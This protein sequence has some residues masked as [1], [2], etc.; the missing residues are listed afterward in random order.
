MKILLIAEAMCKDIPENSEENKDMPCSKNKVMHRK[1]V[2]DMQTTEDANNL[3]LEKEFSKAVENAPSCSNM[4]RV[5]FSI[6]KSKVIIS[7]KN[8]SKESKKIELFSPPEYY[9][10]LSYGDEGN[11]L[12]DQLI[13]V[14]HTPAL[15]SLVA[16]PDAHGGKIF[17]VGISCTYDLNN[18][19]CKIMPEMIGFDINCGVRVW[20]TSI[21]KEEFLSKREHVLELIAKSIPIENRQAGNGLGNSLAI[22]NDRC[23]VEGIGTVSINR[24]I[25]EG[26]KYLVDSRMAST[27]DQTCT[28]YSGSMPVLSPAILS[29][30]AKARGLQQI[31]TLGSGNHYL[32]FQTVSEVFNSNLCQDIGLSID[33]VCV[34]V[35]T[36]S[37]GL[38][39][40]AVH[41]YISKYSAYKNT[42]GICEIPAKS[43]IAQEYLQTVNACSNYAFCNRVL[44]GRSIEGVLSKVF[45]PCTMRP[46][47]DSVHNVIRVEG[48]LLAVRKG[49][50]KMQSKHKQNTSNE[51]RESHLPSI[52][53]VGGSMTTGSYLL[54]A[55]PN[56]SATRNT[57]CHG[58]G[59]IIRRKD[60]KDFITVSETIKEIEEAGVIV[61]AGNED[62]LPEESSKTYK[63]IDKVVQYCEAAGISS[64]VCK[65]VPVAVLK[66]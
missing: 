18:P 13:H 15:D 36:G 31:G 53:S 56:S 39:S 52:V 33:T 19:E 2:N 21:R 4:K 7:D 60:V 16:L 65:L 20:A 37:R 62:T 3:L 11:A 49:S 14:L 24:V 26:I 25:T 28:E 29:Q 43:E 35:H 45:G 23:H 64:R 41:E 1:K 50:T 48:S 58:S 51:H 55:G 5:S 44:I 42:S 47:S 46:I 12:I 63:C 8:S 32:E 10:H 40:R 34:S 61:S 17:P 27:A 6:V 22:N 38:G 59:R 66:G 57:T 54:E 30:K 9:K